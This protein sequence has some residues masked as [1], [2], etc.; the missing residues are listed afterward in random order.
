MTRWERIGWVAEA[1]LL[2]VML[3]NA[4][5]V[6]H[7]GG[8]ALGAGC[9]CTGITLIWWPMLVRARKERDMWIHNAMVAK[10]VLEGLAEIMADGDGKN[11][12]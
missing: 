3:L 1:A 6:G 12:H 5:G 11:V 2:V 7:L 10:S 4:L 8:F 9:G